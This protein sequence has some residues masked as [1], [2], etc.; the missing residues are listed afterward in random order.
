MAVIKK[1]AYF[2]SS[3]GVNKIHCCI[4][5]DDEKEYRG[6]FQIAHGVSEHIERYDEFARFLA[7]KGFVVCGNDHIGHGKS[8]DSFEDLGF[9]AEKDGDVRM[10]DDMHMLYNIMHRRYPELPYF[11]FG[12]SM[13]SFCAR[14][15]ATSFYNELSG[16]ILCGTGELPS[17]AVVLEEPIKFLCKKFGPRAAVPAALIDKL[18]AMTVKDARTGK[19]WLSRRVEN[20]DAY[21]ADPLCGADLKLGGLRDLISLAN[22]A[23]TDEWAYLI[24]PTLPILLVSGAKDPV[25]FNGKGVINVCDNLEDAGHEPK[26]ILYPG[27]RHEILN[28]DD[29]EVVFNDILDFVEKILT[30]VDISEYESFFIQNEM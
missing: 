16:L 7:D 24:P 27:D 1:D 30:P 19:D 12:H 8:V 25:G 22:T 29:R 9:F 14:V 21:I 6:V 18:G 3:T 10:V 17:A 2:E 20:V 26:C 15:Y 28:E 5:L 23:C 11:L 13:G 4:W